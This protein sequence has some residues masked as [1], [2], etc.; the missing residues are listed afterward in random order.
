MTHS[1]ACVQLVLLLLG[2]CPPASMAQTPESCTYA[3]CALRLRHS[4]FSMQLV[5]GEDQHRVASLG[6]F[7]PAVSLFAD[8]SDTAAQYYASFRRRHTGGVLLSLA[9][10]IAMAAGLVAY[11]NN[12]D[13]GVA[14]VVGGG[15]LGIG[16][17]IQ[18]TR[19]R[20][21]LSQAVWWYNRTLPATP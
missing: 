4:L 3:S 7:P 5:Q 15:L 8:R 17:G 14:L 13:L 21:Q 11:D 20:E 16:G 19:A 6:L 1:R 18:A 2:V 10:T 9:G 12:D